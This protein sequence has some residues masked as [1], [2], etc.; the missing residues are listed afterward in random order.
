MYENILRILQ[1]NLQYGNSDATDALLSLQTIT[2]NE[3]FWFEFIECSTLAPLLAAYVCKKAVLRCEQSELSQGQ[4]TSN[5]LEIATLHAALEFLQDILPFALL[6]LKGRT[7]SSLSRLCKLVTQA[8]PHQESSHVGDV[9]AECAHIR[10]LCDD[11]TQACR[12]DYGAA[13]PILPSSCLTS[14]PL[15]VQQY[16]NFNEIPGE[17]QTTPT[18]GPM[19]HHPSRRGLTA[20]FSPR[21]DEAIRT[22]VRLFGHRYRQIYDANQDVWAPGRSPD[23]IEYRW[24]HLKTLL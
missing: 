14:T 12:E 21:E 24:K 16:N 8:T 5:H 17:Q 19:G 22:G 3:R 7:R 9:A 15:C 18:C 1:A 23:Q 2:G 10:G 13:L 4:D 20:P 11:I 6:T